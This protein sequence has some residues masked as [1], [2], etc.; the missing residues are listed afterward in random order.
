MYT[1]VPRITFPKD[2]ISRNIL[3]ILKALII[4]AAV[5]ISKLMKKS[6]TKPMSVPST[7]VKSNLFQLDL[8]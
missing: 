7:I 3:R 6:S 4:V 8:K 2:F 5:D 1:S